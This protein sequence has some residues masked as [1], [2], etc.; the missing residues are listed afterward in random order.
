MR[1]IMVLLMGVMLTGCKTPKIQSEPIAPD[2]YRVARRTEF[3]PAITKKQAYAYA[4]A[5]AAQEGK[6]MVA[7]SEEASTEDALRDQFK[8]DT[9]ELTYRLVDPNDP[10][11]KDATRE[12]PATAPVPIT[13]DDDL[14]TKLTKLKAMRDEGLL[15]DEEFQA[16]KETIMAPK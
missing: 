15:T 5:H 2:T 10:A 7:V 3:G 16:V 9:F 12:T 6:R 8:Y 4:E 14:Y 11:L 13:Q 1:W